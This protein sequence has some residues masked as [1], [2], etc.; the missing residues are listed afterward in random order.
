MLNVRPNVGRVDRRI[1]II[2]VCFAAGTYGEA[3]LAVFV[4]GALHVVALHGAA[5]HANGGYVKIRLGAFSVKQNVVMLARVVAHGAAAAF[6][7]PNNLVLEAAFAEYFVQHKAY[8]RAHAVIYMHIYGA[9]V[10]EQVMAKG[11]YA[12]HHFKVA[13]GVHTVAVCGDFH[14]FA[15]ARQLYGKAIPRAEGRVDVYKIDRVRIFLPK[16][17][18]HSLHGA[19]YEF[20][21][22][23]ER[24]FFPNGSDKIAHIS[25]PLP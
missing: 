21:R 12:A 7:R 2:C 16:L 5:R 14:L 17:L 11:E 8:A 13:G 25:P 19:K 1:L 23:A 15:H 9:C 10:F 22:A 18:R 4:H 24:I 3:Q 20:A 6:V